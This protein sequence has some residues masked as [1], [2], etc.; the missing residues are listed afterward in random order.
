[1]HVNV[2]K[3]TVSISSNYVINRGEYNVNP[4]YFDF[5]DEYTDDLVKKAVFAGEKRFSN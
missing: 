3:N 1:M 2:T 5:S 4:I